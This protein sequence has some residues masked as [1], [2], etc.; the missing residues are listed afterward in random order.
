MLYWY[1]S[2]PGVRVGRPA[3]D[4]DAIRTIE[5]QHPEIEF[6]W[7]HILE[8]GA[9]CQSRSSGDPSVGPAS[10]R[11]TASVG[12]QSRTP[13]GRA[14]VR[15]DGASIGRHRASQ[16]RASNALSEMTRSANTRSPIC[17]PSSSAG[18]S[19][20]AF[21]LATQRSHARIHQIRRG[22]CDACGVA[23]ACRIVES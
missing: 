22:R 10:T 17:W 5:E 8:V 2:A 15:P 11:P 1:R 7:P 23:N 6:D 19:R 13:H 18:I 9:A 20:H 16:P 4:E 21:A 14:S 12:P 3:L